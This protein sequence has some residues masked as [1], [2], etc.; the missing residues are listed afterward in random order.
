MRLMKS[1]FGHQYMVMG[2]W[3]TALYPRDESMR[4]RGDPSGSRLTHA[5][6]AQKVRLERCFRGRS[7]LGDKSGGRAPIK[8]PS[9]VRER[10]VRWE[11]E[12]T[13]PRGNRATA[14]QKD[15][16]TTNKDA[17]QPSTGAPLAEPRL[18]R[19][20]R[21]RA[22][23]SCPAS[24][25]TGTAT[26]E[27]RGN[28]RVTAAARTHRPDAEAGPHDGHNGTGDAPGVQLQHCHWA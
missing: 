23:W 28:A 1:S 27:S 11:P 21:S 6:M 9:P 19:T 14:P 10:A 22:R 20:R 16:A 17:L 24:A 18:T 15:G 4:Y 7:R 2:G 3:G 25:T 26:P 5:E 12:A 8:G 13:T